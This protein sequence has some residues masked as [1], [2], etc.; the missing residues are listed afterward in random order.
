MKLEDKISEILE[1]IEITEEDNGRLILH[2]DYLEDLRRPFKSVPVV[3]NILNLLYAPNKGKLRHLI[4]KNL[5][6]YLQGKVDTSES[7]E[8]KDRYSRLLEAFQDFHNIR[9]ND[10]DVVYIPMTAASKI[11]DTITD[12]LSPVKAVKDLRDEWIEQRWNR[13]AGWRHLIDIPQNPEEELR[14]DTT[15]SGGRGWEL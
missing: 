12:A 10:G 8:E 2:S 9:I 4:A 11:T 7:E 5:E 15:T 14:Y 1:D 6:S 3:R 13:E